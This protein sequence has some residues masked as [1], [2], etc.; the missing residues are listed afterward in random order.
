MKLTRCENDGFSGN[1]GS[2][3]MR[4]LFDEYKHG[5]MKG[6]VCYSHL[7]GRVQFDESVSDAALKYLH[8]TPSTPPKKR[9][10]YSERA[11][12]CTF[13]SLHHPSESLMSDTRLDTFVRYSPPQPVGTSH[14]RL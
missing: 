13:A 7:N 3:L 12:S 8:V 6:H 4:W 2:P 11:A 9:P 10:D 1:A 14:A 5:G